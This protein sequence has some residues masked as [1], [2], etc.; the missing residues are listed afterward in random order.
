MTKA[1][2]DNSARMDQL[3][4]RIEASLVAGKTA[5]TE[6]YVAAALPE[7][8]VSDA[9]CQHCED[10]WKIADA[11][12]KPRAA[13]EADTRSDLEEIK[14]SIRSL[15]IAYSKTANSNNFSAPRQNQNSRFFQ[16]RKR[17]QNNRNRNNTKKNANQQQ[18]NK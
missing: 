1:I 2:A 13:F 12:F 16:N 7:R 10:T 4:N 5:D 14:E 9:G 6:S 17:N 15:Q 3:A 11:R 18:K 8:R